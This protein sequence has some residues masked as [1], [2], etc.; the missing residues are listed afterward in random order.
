V[1]AI[2]IGYTVEAKR[3]VWPDVLAGLCIAYAGNAIVCHPSTGLW[4][5]L[6][7]SVVTRYW[8][9]LTFVSSPLLAPLMLAVSCWAA[10]VNA[11]ATASRALAAMACAATSLLVHAHIWWLIL[12]D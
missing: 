11:F 5:L 12:T 2:R 7:A 3:R 8:A 1:P 4:P 10:Y 9:S 6:Q